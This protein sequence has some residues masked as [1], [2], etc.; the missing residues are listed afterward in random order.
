MS[1]TSQGAARTHNTVVRR[2]F[3]ETKSAFKTTEFYI[4]L[5]VSAAIL[6]AAA[7]TDQGDDGQGFGADHAWQYVAVVTAAYI[8]SRGIAKAGT[9][10]RGNDNDND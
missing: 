1:N 5:I 3:S 6:I 4:W 7:V 2:V 9:R 10:A 8:I